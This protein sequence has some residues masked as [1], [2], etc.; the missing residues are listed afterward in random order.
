MIPQSLVAGSSVALVITQCFLLWTHGSRKSI[1][2][3]ER[4]ALFLAVILSSILLL[5][6]CRVTFL[7][8]LFLLAFVSGGSLLF[9]HR[10]NI[11]NSL[12]PSKLPTKPGNPTVHNQSRQHSTTLLQTPGAVLPYKPLAEGQIRLLKF[13]DDGGS[14]SGPLQ[15]ELYHAKLSQRPDYV[16]LSYSWGQ[17][18]AHGRVSILVSNQRYEVSQNLAEA[19][20][21]LKENKI[22]TVWVDAIC[23]NQRDT[24]E[25]SRE[26]VR[27]FAIYRMAKLVVVWLGSDT[28]PEEEMRELLR[29]TADLEKPVNKQHQNSN[30]GSNLEALERL[31]L[32]R[33]WHR[34]WIIQEVA[35][36]KRAKIFWGSYIFDLRSLEIL[37]RER[38]RSTGE[39]EKSPGLAQKVI[40]VRAACREQQKPRLM[41]ILAMT[42]M[43]ETSVLRDKVYGLLG[44]ASDWADFVQEPNYSQAVSEK[45]LCLEMTSNHI[46]WYSSADIVFLRSVDHRQTELPSWCPDYFHFRPHQFDRNLIPYICG[47]DVNLG[48]ERRRAF[49]QESPNMNEVIPD[50]FHINGGKLT[51]KAFR[52]LLLICHNQS[53]GLQPS[54]AFFSLLFSMPDHVFQ[55]RGYLRVKGWLE[56]H[57]DLLG[58]FEVKVAPS[59]DAYTFIPRRGGGLSPASKVLPEWRD[60]FSLS[61]DNTISRRGEHPLYSML[62]SISSILDEHL[63]LMFIQD[64]ALLG[65]AHRDA[66]P[67]DTVWHLEGCTLQAILRKSVELSEEQGEDI[68]RLVGHAYVDPVLAS[69]RW[70][71]KETRSRLVN[72]C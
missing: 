22:S 65:W 44:L 31:L 58:R 25:K 72:L 71:A 30:L 47:R 38:S 37:L 23:I 12:G 19:L 33:Y 68:Y 51:L 21:K 35:A 46:N 53:F 17:D 66:Q 14:D 43:S 1:R 5:Q 18:A 50:T 55:H 62:E 11:M 57:K 48:W 34:V 59:S 60:F 64:Q 42:S 16:A 13:A 39:D 56:R 36:A 3:G 24:I 63:R 4:I 49:G 8:S 7:S 45:E 67:D 61:E 2:R 28:G 32:Q 69:G 9:M 6:N 29:A 41:D 26:I 70:M 40:S 52:R 27:M 20:R 15:F 10:S 54:S